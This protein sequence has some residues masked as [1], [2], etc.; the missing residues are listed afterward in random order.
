[1]VMEMSSSSLSGEPCWKFITVSLVV[2]PRVPECTRKIRDFQAPLTRSL[3]LSDCGWPGY[4]SG[5]QLLVYACFGKCTKLSVKAK[6]GRG[7]KTTRL[8]E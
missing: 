6:S 5:R 3:S 1:M 2:G 7:P 8:I 4:V